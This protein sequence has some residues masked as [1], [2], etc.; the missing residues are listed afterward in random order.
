MHFHINI[1][2]LVSGHLIE[3]ERLEYKRGWNPVTFYRSIC[4]FANDFENIGGGYILIGIDEENGIAKRPVAGLQPEQL[5]KIQREMIGLNNLIKPFYAP[6]LY[7]EELDK[8]TIIVLWVPGGNSRPYEVP[9]NITAKEKKYQYYIRRYSSSVVANIEEKQELITLA[10][11]IPF[12]DRA[13]TNA[14]AND[15]SSFL[16]REY[17]INAKSKL[18]DMLEKTDRLALLSSLNLISCPKELLFPKNIGL[19]M[20]NDNPEKFFPRSFVEW[21]EF[22]NGEGS[23][24]FFE[25]PT[26]TG[27]IQQ[28]VKQALAYFN[29]YVLKEKITK[30]DTQAESIRIWNYPYQ[31]I[32]EVVVNAAYHKSYEVRE[33]IEI[34]IFPNKIEIINYGGP[35]RSVKIDDINKGI[36]RTRRY[37]NSR[38]GDFFKEMRLCEGK[39]TGIPTIKMAMKSNGSPDAV[40]E[41]DEQRTY[42][43]ATLLIHPEF[44]KFEEELNGGI[45][46]GVSGGINDLFTF[47]TIHPGLNSKQLR[48]KMDVSQRTMERWL[49]ELKDAGKIG[50]NGPNKTGGYFIIE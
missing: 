29:T 40:F 44:R 47:I 50:F 3:G 21:V 27:S 45:N 12:D 16:I 11:Q 15:V 46:G 20:F 49:K 25:R 17:L 18:A 48:E 33:P 37:R 23:P 10:N 41:T 22:P 6:K 26:I 7:I 38:I 30:I 28:Q 31:A 39:G 43:I 36:I 24:E 9:E 32:E 34:R 13:N 14:T 5:D 35:D 19:L 2:E 1:E 4:A 42:F 8:Q